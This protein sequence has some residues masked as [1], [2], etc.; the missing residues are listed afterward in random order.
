MSVIQELFGRSPFG[1]LV[2]HTKKVHACAKL[3][4]PLMEACVKEDHE[5]IHSLQDQVSKL[6]YEADVVKHEIREHLPRRYFLPVQRE[7]LDRFLHCQDEIADYVQDFAVILLIR[8]TKIHP[9][10]VQEFYEFVDQILKTSDLLLAT[11][12]DM[13]GL[14]EASF[15]GAEAQ[16]VLKQISGLNEE[17][18]R[19]DRMQRKLSQHIYQLEKELDPVTIMFYE[20]LLQALSG[21][22]NAAENTGDVL[23]LMIVKG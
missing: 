12:E 16:A 14:V 18:W 8:R 6:E 1:P 9:A 23:R 22:A 2:E 21:I 13:D 20:K 17:E 3:V 10:L 11:A 15:V 19:A 5:A 7:D 4:R